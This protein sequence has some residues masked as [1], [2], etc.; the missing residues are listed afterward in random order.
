MAKKQKDPA[1]LMYSQDFLVGTSI[2]SD[3]EVG[4]YIRLLCY[5]HQIGRLTNDYMDF[6]LKGNCPKVKQKFIRDEEGKWY[7]EKLE[8]EIIRRGNWIE[9][10]RENG[11]KGGRPK[12]N[13]NPSV[14][15]QVNPSVKPIETT[16]TET[17]HILDSII[18]E[19]TKSPKP[20]TRESNTQTQNLE[21]V[22]KEDSPDLGQADR[23]GLDSLYTDLYES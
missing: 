16:R 11:K 18:L 6:V 23:T 10:Q 13:N 22:K 12:A 9:T 21:K 19:D 4:K 7:N 17:E 1:F 3:E 15:P 14:N 5:Q 20:K 2:M 8:Q